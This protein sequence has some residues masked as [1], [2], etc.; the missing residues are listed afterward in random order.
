MLDRQ[1]YHSDAA[2]REY[3]SVSQWKD[4]NDC[5][6]RALARLEGRYKQPEKD[7]FVL[8]NYLHAWADGALDTFC[9]DWRDTVFGRSGKYAEFKKADQAIRFL[10]ADPI[11]RKALDGE[12]EVIMT[13][14]IGGAPWKIRID[15]LGDKRFVDLKYVKD[16]EPLY[17][18]EQG[19]KV[20]FIEFYDYHIQMA[21]YQEIIRQ[22]T[23]KQLE[24]LILAVTKQEP[25]DKAVFGDFTDDDMN[26]ALQMV[27]ITLPRILKLKSGSSTPISC[28]RCD[29]CRRE[30]TITDITP[31]KY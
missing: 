3:L 2:N 28:G 9:E 15:V 4:F 24:P 20:S 5:E 26:Q 22:N 31:W 27:S 7:A 10:E 18:S 30:K 21:V 25:P 8:G 23:G 12:H 16:F 6:T 11:A 19:S 14:E 13:G 1:S 29:Y 17:S